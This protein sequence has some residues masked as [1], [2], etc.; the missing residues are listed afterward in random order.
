MV[1]GFA[2]LY[3]GYA[4]IL[5]T[6]SCGKRAIGRPILRPPPVQHC[7]LGLRHHPR[8]HH[9][10]RLRPTPSGLLVA[11]LDTDTARI[12]SNGFE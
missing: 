6:D 9:R 11:R 7:L 2:A 5:Q 4:L 12:F 3:P 1:L 10:P 8:R